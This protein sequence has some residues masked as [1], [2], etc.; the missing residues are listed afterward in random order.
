MFLFVISDNQSRYFATL[1]PQLKVQW[2]SV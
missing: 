2:R 1:K